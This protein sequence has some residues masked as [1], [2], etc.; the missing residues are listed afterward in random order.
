MKMGIKSEEGALNGSLGT[1][2]RRYLEKAVAMGDVLAVKKL[3]DCI[4][5]A[6][7]TQHFKS[8]SPSSKSLSNMD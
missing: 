8:P 5:P 6:I 2:L 7:P 3:F 1:D 4:M